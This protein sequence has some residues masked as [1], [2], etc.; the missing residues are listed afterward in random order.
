MT[1][2]IPM[3]ILIICIQMIHIMTVRYKHNT[4]LTDEDN[5]INLRKGQDTEPPEPS[6]N[7]YRNLTQLLW[8][9]VFFLL[10]ALFARAPCHWFLESF[11][12]SPRCAK[13]FLL[14]RPVGRRDLSAGPEQKKNTTQGVFFFAPAPGKGR[15]RSGPAGSF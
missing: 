1:I 10:W 14:L 6:W 12:C 7:P 13:C 11:C 15:G 2:L 5:P 4:S 8:A 9:R 3:V